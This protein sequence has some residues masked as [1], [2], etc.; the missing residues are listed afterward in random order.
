[1][2]TIMAQEH[3]RHF[4]VVTEKGR[5]VGIVSDRDLMNHIAQKAADVMTSSL[6][7]VAPTTR[8]GTAISQMINRNISCLPVIE[9]ETL[10]G[11][12]T[13]TDAILTLQCILQLWQRQRTPET[14]GLQEVMV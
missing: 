12:L 10:V 7:T 3:V 2:R 11:I 4:P 5:L 6:I 1:M 9:G 14:Q 13:T 8:F